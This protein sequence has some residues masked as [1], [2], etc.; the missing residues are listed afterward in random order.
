MSEPAEKVPAPLE[1]EIATHFANYHSKSLRKKEADQWLFSKYW[2][3]EKG[4][5]PDDRPKPR[6]NSSAIPS[7]SQGL[8]PLKLVGKN[9]SP[10]RRKAVWIC[11]AD[12]EPQ[13]ERWLWFRRVPLDAVSMFAGNAGDGKSSL[14]LA[15]AAGI[16]RGMSWPDRPNEP[17]EVGSVVIL[18]AEMNLGMVVRARLEAEG[19]DMSLVHLLET[20][21]DEDGLPS[22]FSLARDIP[23][24][25]EKVRKINEVGPKVRL[26]IID[27]IGSY[28]HGADE[29]SNNG[30]HGL[31]DPL[32]RFAEEFGL[33]MLLLA[34]LNKSMSTDILQRIAGSV[35]FGATA[36]MIWYVSDHPHDPARKILSFVKGNALESYKLGL[37][38]SYCEGRHKWDPEPVRWVANEVAKLLMDQVPADPSERAGDRG[39]ERDAIKAAIAVIEEALVSGPARQDDLREA[40][41]EEGISLA[42]FKRTLAGL[43]RAGKV[44]EC[45]GEGKRKWVRWAASLPLS[46]PA[47]PAADR[48]QVS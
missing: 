44:E 2:L 38:Y 16:T 25:E 1:G 39:P 3:I 30:I 46:E 23:V 45:P 27:P 40:V 24:L 31:I 41:L 8:P 35:A 5:I 18:Q 11:M 22:P 12:V 6:A 15:V 7:P 4:L 42:T 29:N 19:A 26:V 14:A 48:A 10:S 9:G 21:T 34:H 28:T 17:V 47:E 20:V 13:P 32:R 36:R 33:A 37:S 43:K